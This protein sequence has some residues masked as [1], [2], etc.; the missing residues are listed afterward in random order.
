MLLNSVEQ[1]ERAREKKI[2]MGQSVAWLFNAKL[3]T[4]SKIVCVNCEKS[5]ICLIYI[6]GG[7]PRVGG[8]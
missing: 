2:Q 8:V 3:F 5:P 7:C 6:A 1:G 4:V